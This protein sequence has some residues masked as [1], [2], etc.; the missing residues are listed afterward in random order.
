MELRFREELGPRLDVAIR[1]PVRLRENRQDRIRRDLREQGA[2][3]ETHLATDLIGRI[4]HVDEEEDEVGLENL[5]ERCVECLD[6]PERH[7]VDEADRVREQ[8]PLPRAS[9]AP[10]RR[11]E[12]GE[13]AVVH[14]DTFIGQGVQQRRLARVRVPG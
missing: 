12:G 5:L 7:P 8:D 2:R 11:R 1:K 4:G 9:E 6:H 10:R 13:H 14:E 3:G